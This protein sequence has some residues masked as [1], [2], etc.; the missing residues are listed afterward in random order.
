MNGMSRSRTGADGR[1]TEVISDEFVPG[2]KNS[3]GPNDLSVADEPLSLARSPQAPFGP[4]PPTER[5]S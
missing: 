2:T 5:R 4:C 1:P 3:A